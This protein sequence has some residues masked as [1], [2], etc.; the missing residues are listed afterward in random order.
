VRG[1]LQGDGCMRRLFTLE[2]S[3]VRGRVWLVRGEGV[4]GKETAI[5][6]LFAFWVRV[7]GIGYASPPCHVERKW[8]ARSDDLWS[9]DIP[10]RVRGLCVAEPGLECR[11][12]WDDN[13]KAYRGPLTPE[14]RSYNS[15]DFSMRSFHSLSRNDR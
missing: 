13:G 1:S 14:R 11:G 6:G 8:P 15:G 5:G 9:R 3:V 7:A 4:R 2:W 12:H 10:G